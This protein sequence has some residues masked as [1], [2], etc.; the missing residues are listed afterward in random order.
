MSQHNKTISI[1]VAKIQETLRSMGL[2]DS[3]IIRSLESARIEPSKRKFTDWSKFRNEITKL[4]LVEGTISRDDI[5]T[6]KYAPSKNTKNIRKIITRQM[7]QISSSQELE[8]TQSSCSNWWSI[9]GGTLVERLQSQVYDYVIS[10]PRGSSFKL[11]L[12]LT[13]NNID[14]KYEKDMWNYLMNNKDSHY[15]DKNNPAKTLT[16][17]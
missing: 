10:L 1:D 16:R 14:N 3:Q 6:L 12:Y 2:T 4:L 9:E 15:T 7:A 11:K 8:I 17:L 5:M 13:A